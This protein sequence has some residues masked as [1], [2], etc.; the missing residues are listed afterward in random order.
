MR[1]S[2]GGEDF[3]SIEETSRHIDRFIAGLGRFSVTDFLPMPNWMRPSTETRGGAS[4][5]WVRER[6]RVHGRAAQERSA[7]HLDA[8]QRSR[9]P[10]ARCSRSR[11]RP[12]DGRQSWCATTSW[13]LSRRAMKRLPMLSRGRYGLS[14]PMRRRGTLLEKSQPLLATTARRRASRPAGIHQTGPPGNDASLP[15]RRQP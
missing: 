4:T 14:P 8:P 7:D 10:S 5:A 9:R 11:D 15:W 13:D 3:P 6:V 12:A 2:P 1:R